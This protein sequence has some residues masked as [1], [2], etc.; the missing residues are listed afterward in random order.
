MQHPFDMTIAPHRALFVFAVV[1][2]VRWFTLMAK[3]LPEKRF[4]IQLL[5]AWRR[6][7]HVTITFQPGN[8]YST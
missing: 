2:L 7:S 5:E 3:G 8:R 4:R 6:S 1:N